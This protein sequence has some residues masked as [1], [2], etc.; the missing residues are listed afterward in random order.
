MLLS[1]CKHFIYES[2]LGWGLFNM[3]NALI[4]CTYVRADCSCR[5]PN[6]MSF[7]LK[8]LRLGMV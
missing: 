7:L 5:K 1:N 4:L 8:C 3:L 2:M 6:Y